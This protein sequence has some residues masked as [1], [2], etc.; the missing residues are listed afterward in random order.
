MEIFKYHIQQYWFLRA[1]NFRTDYVLV[2]Q[3]FDVIVEA[4][5]AADI[6]NA[7]DE[8]MSHKSLH[9]T[10]IAYDRTQLRCNLEQTSLKSQTM[11]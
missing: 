8:T 1:T 4:H 7:R 5:K 9:S 6:L 2:N 11:Q 10:F 3:S